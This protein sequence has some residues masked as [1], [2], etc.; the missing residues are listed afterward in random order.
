[1]SHATKPVVSVVIPTHNYGRFLRYTLKNLLADQDVETDVI[2]VDDGSTDDTA[3]VAREFNNEI[4]Y[5]QL[6]KTGVSAARNIGMDAARGEYLALVDADDLLYPGTLRSQC[7][8]L[9]ANP[10]TRIAVCFNQMFYGEAPAGPYAHADF[11]PLVKDSF[12]I[13][14][15]ARNI[16]PLHAYM[17][18]LEDARRIGHFDTELLAVED[19]EFWF[20]CAMAGYAISVNPRGLALY[21][22]HSSNTTKQ[23]LPQKMFECLLRKRIHAALAA[24]E[25]FLPDHRPDAWMAHASRCF[26]IAASFERPR[27]D[28]AGAML[29]LGSS[30]MKMVTK[31]IA[32]HSKHWTPTDAS[33]KVM[34]CN[35]LATAHLLEAFIA[36]GANAL[37]KHRNF[38]GR[39]FPEVNLPTNERR[40]L[41]TETSLATH[42]PGS[43]V[44]DFATWELAWRNSVAER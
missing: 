37:Q 43:Y 27:P 38:L 21:R 17:L 16:A 41:F 24:N 36:E 44:K 35:A 29:D 10:E 19:Y 3:E 31:E 39:Y 5:I 14:F 13:H 30:A 42:L 18:R 9:A 34:L 32:M 6:K 25:N 26:D 1:M 40:N 2:V 15:C 23:T 28:V 8:T 20:R 7:D 12:A 11:F 33:R 4:R 22:Q